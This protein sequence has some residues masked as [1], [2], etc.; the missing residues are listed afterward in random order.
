M[1]EGATLFRPADYHHGAEHALMAVA[2]ARLEKG[3]DLLLG[4]GEDT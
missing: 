2:R 4:E 3:G 1:A